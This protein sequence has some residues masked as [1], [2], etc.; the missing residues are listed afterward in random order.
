MV[1]V[2]GGSRRCSY[3]CVG[4]KGGK[5][6][7][8][9][10]DFGFRR[11]S[12]T[13]VLK[14]AVSGLQA[15]LPALRNP[16]AALPAPPRPPARLAI[17]AA[18]RI[19]AVA[20]QRWGSGVTFRAGSRRGARRGAGEAQGQ[21]GGWAH[22]RGRLLARLARLPGTHNP[23]MP[24]KGA[25]GGDDEWDARTRAVRAAAIGVMA[26]R[27]GTGA[28]MSTQQGGWKGSIFA[29]VPT[30]PAISREKWAACGARGVNDVWRT[31]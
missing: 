10:P 8:C 20:P 28:R 2:R 29:R 26:G 4:W 30:Q 5:D 25:K 17:R 13:P 15:P 18:L 16:S 22:L 3:L 7:T 9:E 23:G 12:P 6:E 31:L 1:C 11:S 24:R 19:R 21:L 14:T 27:A